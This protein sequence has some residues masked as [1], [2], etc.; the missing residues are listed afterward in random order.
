[1]T[2]GISMPR[3]AKDGQALPGARYLS[4]LIFKSKGPDVKSEALTLMHMT[5]G[6]LLDHDM[7][8]SP[9]AKFL[10]SDGNIVTRVS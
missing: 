4:S 3:V 5:F 9:N 7:D 6:Q 2:S 1:M 8:L 10:N